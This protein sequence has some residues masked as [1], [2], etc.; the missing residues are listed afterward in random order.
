MIREI[1]RELPHHV[2]TW[3]DERELLLGDHLN[4]SIKSAI[5][6]ESDFVVI[7]IGPEAVRSKWVK[8]ELEWALEHERAIKRIFVLPVLLDRKSW[9]HLPAEF[10]KR[11]YL[12]CTDFSESAIK[13][14]SERLANE[15]FALVTASPF[16]SAPQNFILEKEDSIKRREL[17]KRIASRVAD[18]Q[19]KSTDQTRLTR[20]RLELI[21]SSLEPIRKVELLCLFE[22]QFGK[23]KDL[24]LTTDLV[25]AHLLRIEVVVGQEEHLRK[26]THIIDWTS[27]PF[28]SLQVDWGLGNKTYE[29]RDVFLKAIGKLSNS[30]KK[31]LFS[32]IE[33][34]RCS[35]ER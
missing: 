35:F 26:W 33:I 19:E 4:D 32:S 14:F 12:P 8:I 24:L 6:R 10:Q 2:K 20:E 16:H 13:N 5:T 27:G 21:V 3:I 29:V 15:L 30:E 22:L 7:F 28:N 18:N 1:Q 34:M 11:R 9:K 17:V 31:E 23:Y 25:K